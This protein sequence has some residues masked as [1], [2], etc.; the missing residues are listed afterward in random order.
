M[1]L[2]NNRYQGQIVMASQY[3]EQPNFKKYKAVS[4]LPS[5]FDKYGDQSHQDT[6]DLQGMGCSYKAKLE[7]QSLFINDMLT[8][9]ASNLIKDLLCDYKLDKQGVFVDIANFKS[10]PMH[11]N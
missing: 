10:N 2:G 1:D 8:V 9:F 3:I 5:L 11:L 6:E 4:K 7:E